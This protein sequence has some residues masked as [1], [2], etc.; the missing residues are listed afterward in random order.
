MTRWEATLIFAGVLRH[1]VGSLRSNDAT[2]TR[3]S[4]KKSEFA[5]FQSLSRLFLPTYFV[6][7]RRTLLKLNSKGPY[8]STEREIKFGRCL[9]TFPM[10]REIRNFHVVVVQKRQ[11]NAQKVW[12]TCKVVNCCCCCFFDVLV[13][14]ASL[15]LK[16]PSR[17]R[18]QRQ[19]RRRRQRERQK[20]NRFW[21]A[22]QQLCTCI[23]LFCT[24]LCSH[25][26]T[27]TWKWLIS[28]FVEDAN[29]RQ[30]LP[31]SFPELLKNGWS[32]PKTTEQVNV[33]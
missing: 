24:F 29:T 14:V 19:R 12:C 30:R 25:C 32:S 20:S 17:E 16:V 7:C 11:R 13:A 2:A 3:T 6:E 15:D 33:L 26:T 10:K 18:R 9:F 28:R 23:T 22:K 1:P 5:L 8:P 21:L 31:F 4:L 27:T